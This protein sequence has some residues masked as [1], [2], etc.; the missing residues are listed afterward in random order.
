MAG[1]VVSEAQ[2][3][4]RVIDELRVA[5]A[6]WTAE[7]IPF[8][9]CAISQCDI[10]LAVFGVDPAAEWRGR[11]TTVRGMRRVMGKG[12]LPGCLARAARRLKWRRIKPADAK[13]GDVGIVIAPPGVAIVRLMRAGEWVGRNAHGFSVL[14]TDAVRAAWCIV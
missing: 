11:Y 2:A 8:D 1:R 13:P 5:M 4:R 9:G 7:P 10:H 3:R 12:G 14:P 6:K